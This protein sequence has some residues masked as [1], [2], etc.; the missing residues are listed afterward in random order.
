MDFLFSPLSGLVTAFLLQGSGPIL[1]DVSA[2]F[3]SA[4]VVEQR[5]AEPVAAPSIDRLL[6]LPNGFR[7]PGYEALTISRNSGN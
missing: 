4:P 1:P 3:A 6:A 2:L 7:A 5:A